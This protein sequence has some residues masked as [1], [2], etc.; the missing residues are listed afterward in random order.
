M[1]LLDTLGYHLLPRV[2]YSTLEIMLLFLCVCLS[3]SVG[4][5]AL[6]CNVQGCQPNR[7]YV[8]DE[9][10]G[11]SSAE[12]EWKIQGHDPTG[13]GCVSTSKKVACPLKSNR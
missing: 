8:F 5:A 6:P 1:M 2:L 10:E 3:L 4:S 7:Q 9:V 11:D 13:L 12:I